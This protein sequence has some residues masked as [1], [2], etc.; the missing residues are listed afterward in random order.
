[1]DVVHVVPGESDLIEFLDQHL[2]VFLDLLQFF[3]FR[4]N[5][6]R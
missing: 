2:E 6:H 5:S 3:L 4:F 1:M